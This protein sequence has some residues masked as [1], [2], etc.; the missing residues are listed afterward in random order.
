MI[1]T[2]A[3]GNKL[4]SKFQVNILKKKTFL[5]IHLKLKKNWKSD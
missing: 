3:K 5:K 2:N 1:D 4:S